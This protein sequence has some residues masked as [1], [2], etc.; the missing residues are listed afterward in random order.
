M[1]I[2][3]FFPFRSPLRAGRGVLTAPQPERGCV[4]DQP[5]QLRNQKRI[6]TSKALQQSHGLRLML[7]MQ[8]RS[9]CIEIL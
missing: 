7:R 5:Q 2:R 1:N 9:V 3:Q 4:E 8:P 6:R